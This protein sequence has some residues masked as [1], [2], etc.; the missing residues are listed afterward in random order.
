[1]SKMYVPWQCF[2]QKNHVVCTAW[3]L[4]IC[5]NLGCQNKVLQGRRNSMV[6]DWKQQQIKDQKS[7][8][9][10]CTWRQCLRILAPWGKI[11]QTSVCSQT[12]LSASV[13]V[14]ESC[15][16]SGSVQKGFWGFQTLWCHGNLTPSACSTLSPVCPC[17]TDC[18]SLWEYRPDITALVDWA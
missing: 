16:V 11:P 10:W 6:K 8:W 9:G 7:H 14:C 1:M 13:K 3:K 4:E 15:Y 17:L 18:H 5:R 12:V 2:V